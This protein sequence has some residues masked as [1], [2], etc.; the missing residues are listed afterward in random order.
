MDGVLFDGK[1][2]PVAYVEHEGE[3]MLY[4]WSGHV[5]AYVSGDLVFGWNGNHLGWYIDGVVY[6]LRGQRVG[7]TAEKCPRAL[8]VLRVKAPKRA[9]PP[10]HARHAEHK[11]PDFRPTYGEQDFEDFLKGG[12]ANPEAL[13]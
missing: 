5:A 1:G 12:V 11:R 7:S 2:R 3:A 10:K 4:L 9:R 8:Q 13:P 6:D